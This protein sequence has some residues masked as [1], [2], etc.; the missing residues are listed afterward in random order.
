MRALLPILLLLGCDETII[1]QDHPVEFD[2]RSANDPTSGE[3]GMTLGVYHEQLFSPLRDGDSVHIIDGFQ[4]GTWVHISIRV[5]GL[6]R[7]GNVRASLEDVGEIEYEIDLAR[8]AE[9]FLEAYD[10]PIP[11]DLEDEE[12]DALLGQKRRLEVTYGGEEKV[13]IDRL[14]VLERG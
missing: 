10:I 8:T 4:G 13:T 5:T 3:P 14:V 12:I 9:G 2:Q 11:A 6:P 7:S 1:Y